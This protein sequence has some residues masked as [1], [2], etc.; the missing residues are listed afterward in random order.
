MPT[1]RVSDEELVCL[2]ILA[3]VGSTLL[4]GEV[5]DHLE[6]AN[7]MTVTV[8]SESADYFRHQLSMMTTALFALK[9]PDH[10]PRSISSEESEQY[11]FKTLELGAATNERLLEA[12][13][14]IF[15]ITSRR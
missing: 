9:H 3:A 2:S 10:D 14:K 1:L 13:V 8:H 4:G 7:A 12:A 15:D 6:E 5:D 11:F